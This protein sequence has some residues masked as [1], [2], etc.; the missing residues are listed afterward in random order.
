MV[1]QFFRSAEGLCGWMCWLWMERPGGDT[2]TKSDS[3]P[4]PP[5]LLISHSM[6]VAQ[7]VSWGAPPRV[8]SELVSKYR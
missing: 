5:N 4:P 3:S 6:G 7:S 2:C 1:R 8:G